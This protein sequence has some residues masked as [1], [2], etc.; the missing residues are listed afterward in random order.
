MPGRSGRCATLA[1]SWQR[2]GAEVAAAAEAAAAAAPAAVA[3]AA[4]AM[5]VCSP[6]VSILH[7]QFLALF[8]PCAV[9]R[10]D[11]RLSEGPARQPALQF[12][13]LAVSGRQCGLT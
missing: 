1:A 12:C 2:R 10:P 5:L 11:P 3:A 8:L 13:Q 9:R 6:S 7:W 4:A